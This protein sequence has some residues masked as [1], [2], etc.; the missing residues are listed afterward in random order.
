MVEPLFYHDFV[1]ERGRSDLSFVVSRALYVL[2][3]EICDEAQHARI[4]GEP[5]QII[6]V[7]KKLE[8][9]IGLAR[10]GKALGQELTDLIFIEALHATV[11]KGAT[12]RCRF[13]A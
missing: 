10:I 12:N 9:T 7:A 1:I 5:K 6:D 8:P 3:I 2:S 11:A 4:F 13:L